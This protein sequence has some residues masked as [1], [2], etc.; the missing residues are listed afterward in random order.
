MALTD[1]LPTGD[2]GGLTVVDERLILSGLIAKNSDGTP[3]VG[4]FPAGTGILV[5]GRASMGYDVAPF[6]AATSRTGTGVELLANDATVT[7]VATDA[8]PGANSRID[9]IYVRPQF[10]ANADAGNV[11]VLGV[12]KGTAAPVPTKPAIP[13]GALELATAEIP[14][15]ATS[16]ASVVI[17]QTAPMTAAAG[18]IVLVRNA[19]ELTAFL[20]ADGTTARVLST[21]ATFRRQGGAWVAGAG[22]AFSAAQAS[23]NSGGTVTSSPNFGAL[24][25]IAVSQQVVAAAACRAKV[26]L[27]FQYGANGAGTGA[28]LSVAASGA[29]TITPSNTGVEM[30]QAQQEVPGM[31]NTYSGSWLLSLNAGTTT[32]A[33]VGRIIGAGGTRS[34]SN[35]V[36]LVEPVAE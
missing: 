11:P 21:G 2:A 3:R 27:T 33:V 23:V 1:S 7:N 36:L 18:G 34:V 9:V 26:T 8:A 5:T 12:A 17:T 15:T 10:T 31:T 14:S 28:Q 4:V 32:L 24:A 22:A 35:I 13:A 20:A 6:K 16:T 25:S 29:T 19:S 30:V